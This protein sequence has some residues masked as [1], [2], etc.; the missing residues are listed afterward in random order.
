MTQFLQQRIDPL[1]S[2]SSASLGTATPRLALCAPLLRPTEHRRCFVL[3]RPRQ[4]P[5]RQPGIAINVHWRRHPAA[6]A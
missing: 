4:H 6:V 2:A 5:H 3:Q 1:A